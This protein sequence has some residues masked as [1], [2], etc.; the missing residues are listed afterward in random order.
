MTK[1]ERLKFIRGIY[2]TG[3]DYG[4]HEAEVPESFFERWEDE[5]MQ[6][7]KHQDEERVNQL[8]KAYR[9]GQASVSCMKIINGGQAKP[10]HL[11]DDEP[12]EHKI[13][14][15]TSSA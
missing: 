11:C 14:E 9:A 4:F 6:L 10:S 3:H 5:L 12:C 13:S 2:A 7:L 15:E 1:E 8:R